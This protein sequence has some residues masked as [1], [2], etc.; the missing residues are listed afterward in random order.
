MLLIKEVP[1]PVEGRKNYPSPSR[2]FFEH[3]SKNI[4]GKKEGSLL[5]PSTSSGTKSDSIFYSL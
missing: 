5:F 1:E 4:A 3:C 2:Q